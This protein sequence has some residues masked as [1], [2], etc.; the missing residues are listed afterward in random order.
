MKKYVF[1]FIISL[2]FVISSTAQEGMWLLN[3]I[4][5]LGLEK[6]GLKIKTSEI[7]NPDKPALY[8]AVVQLGGGTASFVSPDG[9]LITNHHVAFGALQRVST[10]ETDYLTNGFLAKNRSDEI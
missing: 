5:Q 6:K 2:L 4:D 1:V 9:L 3:Q 8:N 7:F 10:A